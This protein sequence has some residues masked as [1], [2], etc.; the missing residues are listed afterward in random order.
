MTIEGLASATHR[1][2]DVRHDSFDRR[3]PHNRTL[4][5][6]NMERLMTG[7]DMALMEDGITQL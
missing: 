5:L 4:I 7:V 1:G 6:V 3:V 2:S